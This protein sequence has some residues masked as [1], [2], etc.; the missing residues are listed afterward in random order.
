M[1]HRR[2]NSHTISLERQILLTFHSLSMSLVFSDPR[3]NF[4]TVTFTWDQEELNL[5]EGSYYVMI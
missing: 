1:H 2:E 4:E 5:S 3:V